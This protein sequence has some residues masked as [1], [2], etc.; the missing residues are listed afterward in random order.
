[1]KLKQQMSEPIDHNKIVVLTG[2]G[3]SAESGLPTFRDMGGLWNWYSITE[4]ASPEA[5]EANPQLVLDF[6][7]ERRSQPRPTRRIGHWRNWRT[8]M[9][10]S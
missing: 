3:I 10:S 9:R 6:Y 2:A 1:M 8:V 5:W 7:N 4:V